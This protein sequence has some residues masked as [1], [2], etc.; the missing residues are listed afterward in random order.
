MTMT[1]FI[2]ISLRP[3]LYVYRIVVKRYGHAW[4]VLD[5][6]RSIHW[7]RVHYGRLILRHRRGC[8]RCCCCYLGSYS[9]ICAG[10]RGCIVLI[11]HVEHSRHATAGIPT[12]GRRQ[13]RLR[14][15]KMVVPCGFLVRRRRSRASEI[16]KFWCFQAWFVVVGAHC[17]RFGLHRKQNNSNTRYKHNRSGMRHRQVEIPTNY[18]HI[19]VRS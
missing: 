5:F 14:L 16:R 3:S 12:A 17:S 9:M 10:P 2:K 15:A 13:P 7:R 19:A 18:V 1:T 4:Y 6:R 8:R 11:F